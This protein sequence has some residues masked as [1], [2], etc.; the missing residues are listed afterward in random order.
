MMREP[1]TAAGERGLAAVLADPARSVVAVDF[2]GPLA[3]LVERPEDARAARGAVEALAALASRVGRCA[4][5][6]GRAAQDV[7][8]LGGLAGVAHL[9][10][11]GH[12]GLEEWYDGSLTSPDPSPAASAGRRQGRGG[13]TA[14]R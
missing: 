2:D 10:V 1:T 12:Y 7:V 3:P 9:H 5:V 13:T 14:R 6:T 8:R 4:V 11:L